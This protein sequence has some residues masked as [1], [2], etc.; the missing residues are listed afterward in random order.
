MV[1]GAFHR[2]RGRDI[3]ATSRPCLVHNWK[4][5]RLSALTP[6]FAGFSRSWRS[7]PDCPTNFRPAGRACFARCACCPDCPWLCSP[8]PFLPFPMRAADHSRNLQH[9]RR[10]HGESEKKCRKRAVDF[11]RESA[12]GQALG[13]LRKAPVASLLSLSCLAALSPAAS[14]KY[15][16]RL[17]S[18]RA[19]ATIL[20]REASRSAPRLGS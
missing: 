11:R 5:S 3:V 20:P 12:P 2:C 19:G 17:Q 9:H 7:C 14:R 16:G 1:A 13:F 6:G 10:R 18:H 15:H 8:P 4:F